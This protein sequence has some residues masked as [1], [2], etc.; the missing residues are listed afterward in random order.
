MQPL[1]FIIESFF[2]K[3]TKHAQHDLVRYFLKS[4]SV[5]MNIFR[6]MSKISWV[7]MLNRIPAGD[8]LQNEHNMYGLCDFL[9]NIHSASMRLWFSL[10]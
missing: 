3:N 1:C 7:E 4:F 8:L 9:S 2:L 5:G 10:N 6:T